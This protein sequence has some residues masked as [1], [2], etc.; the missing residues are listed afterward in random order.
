MIYSKDYLVYSLLITLLSY[1]VYSNN[2]NKA[3]SITFWFKLITST[4]GVIHH[5]R[6]KSDELYFYMNNRLGRKELLIATLTIDI[7]FWLIGM[8]I[9]V[10][11]MA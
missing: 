3:V 9:L 4:L 7:G 8:I 5:Q 11:I 1:Y 10:K 2:G 6:R